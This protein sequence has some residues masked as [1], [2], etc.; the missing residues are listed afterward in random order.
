MKYILMI[1]L[2]ERA[3]HRMRVM[4]GK[5]FL[6]IVLLLKGRTFDVRFLKYVPV[7]LVVLEFEFCSLCVK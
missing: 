5:A 3:A 2:S 6:L 7:E 1:S 4:K